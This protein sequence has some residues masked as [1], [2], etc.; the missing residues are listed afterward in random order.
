MMNLDCQIVLILFYLK[1]YIE[2]FIKRHET[3][4]SISP[5]HVYINRINNKLVFKIQDGYKLET[6]VNT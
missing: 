1:N 6:S 3:L 2:Y 5:I 4:T